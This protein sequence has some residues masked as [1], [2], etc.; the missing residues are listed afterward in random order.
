[1]VGDRRYE[2]VPLSQFRFGN[3]WTEAARTPSPLVL[4]IGATD[5]VRVRD[6]TTNEII[7]SAP[8]ADV[9]ATPASYSYG[10]S[11][12]ADPVTESIL[13][14]TLPDFPPLRIKPFRM[15]GDWGEYRYGWRDVVDRADRP[16]YVV[17]EA[18]WLALI[19]TFGL[20]DRIP[21]DH[22]ARELARRNRRAAI[23]TVAYVAA[24]VVLLALSAYLNHIS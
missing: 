3:F 10:G 24:L 14:L 13:V 1:M 7:A 22:A 6:L 16:G 19:E 23:R 8:L 15:R 18:I 21:D 4:A 11:S 9:K 20:G 2:L 17:S 12:E 5:V